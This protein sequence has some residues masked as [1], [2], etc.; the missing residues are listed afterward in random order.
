[1]KRLSPAFLL[2]SLLGLAL[3]AAA[4]AAPAAPANVYL[5]DPRTPVTRIEGP[6]RWIG[7]LQL[8]GGGWCT[9]GL[10]GKDLILTA[11]HCMI[12]P[13]GQF[14]PGRYQFHYGYIAGKAAESSDVIWFQWGGSGSLSQGIEG[15]INDWAIGILAQPLGAKH[16][17]MGYRALP[18]DQYDSQI[19]GFTGYASDF[20]GGQTAAFQWGCR[21]R[22]HYDNGLLRT[23]CNA[24][25]GASGSPIYRQVRGK[26][27]KIGYEVIAL[28]V[29]EYRDGGAKSLT[30]IPYSD[31]H[32][33][34]AVPASQF[35]PTLL[36]I[37]TERD[38]K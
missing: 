37:A 15:R 18:L 10:V 6:S 14:I 21:F 28:W 30:G 33:N 38:R 25:T 11:A 16:G 22:G 20:Q 23:D 7:R 1:M 13:T 12:S 34:L 24:S 31:S 5:D 35:V 8:P 36:Q 9:A 32:A 4:L 19:L 26:N 3:S 2:T 27:G 17:W 29:A